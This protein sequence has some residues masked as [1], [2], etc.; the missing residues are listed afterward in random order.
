MKVTVIGCS[1][2]FAGPDSPASSYLVQAEHDGRT[3]NLVLDLG[4]GSL[5][6]LQRY[7]DLADVDAI[8]ISHLH[9]DHCADLTGYYV[10]RTYHPEG[11]MPALPVYA[12]QGAAERITRMYA[13]DKPEDL[14]DRFD[15]RDLTDE[16]TF[17]VGPFTVTPYKVEHPVEAY[18]VRVEADGAVVAYTG[19][20][21][22]TPSLTPLMREADLVLADAAFVDG[23][24][25]A[26]RGVHLSGSRAAQAAVDAGGV[27]HLV[28]THI[29][30]WNDPQVCREQA[31][32]VWPGHVGI[33]RAG[34][35]YQLQATP[36]AQRPAATGSSRAPG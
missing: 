24:D 3:W 15:F 2:S 31:E 16:K 21:D 19:D 23:R 11:S 5:G 8:V 28:L 13:V 26:A 33:A 20:T 14:R 34:D 9:P 10:V 25:D 29:P 32:S 27:K 6:A 22:T 36:A 18:G 12:P 7:V 17:Q 35:T 4:N 1:G 30:A